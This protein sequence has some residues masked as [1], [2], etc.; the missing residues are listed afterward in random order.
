M[1]RLLMAAMTL[2]SVAAAVG[3]SG[4]ASA[5]ASEAKAV[6]P[7]CS[8]NYPTTDTQICPAVF[9]ARAGKSAT[10]VVAKYADFSSCNFPAPASEPGDNGRYVVAKISIKWGDGTAATSGVA[11]RGSP[12]T[13]TNVLNSS[14]VAE[15]ITGVHRYK[16]RG[17]YHLSVTIIYRRGAGDTFQNCAKVT[18]V[19]KPYSDLTNCIALGAPVRSV[20][21]VRAS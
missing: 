7:A 5:G 11:H 13:G 6:V 19:S 20:A 14:G 12:C 9:T 3:I 16:S 10:F 4:G 21:V 8:P 1:R 17:T 2:L 18:G 15:S